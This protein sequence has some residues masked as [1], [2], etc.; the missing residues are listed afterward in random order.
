MNQ[1]SAIKTLNHYGSLA[2]RAHES[3]MDFVPD[4]RAQAEIRQAK[5][6]LAESRLPASELVTQ[7]A[8]DYLYT[9]DSQ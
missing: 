6:K 5:E 7:V 9:E 3:N 8:Y 4:K 1:K 2:K